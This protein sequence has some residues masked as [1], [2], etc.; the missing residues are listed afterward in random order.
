MADTDEDWT[1]DYNDDFPLNPDEATD[2]DSDWIFD[3]ALAECKILL[4]NI[5]SKFANFNSIG[6]IGIGL[7]GDS[8]LSQGQAEKERL[9]ETLRLEEGH[10]GYGIFLG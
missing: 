9:E 6:N 8:L 3:Y 1:D 4:G 2:T 5:R 10:E 7:D